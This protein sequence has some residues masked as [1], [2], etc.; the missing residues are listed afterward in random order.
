[1]DYNQKAIL[2]DAQL[3]A[4]RVQE[5]SKMWDIIRATSHLYLRDPYPVLQKEQGEEQWNPSIPRDG[6]IQSPQ[7]CLING[8]AVMAA[9]EVHNWYE[10]LERELISRH[11]SIDVKNVSREA[12]DL[13]Y[14]ITNGITHY[15][16]TF[17]DQL[18][19]K[20]RSTFPA[21]YDTSFYPRNLGKVKE[22]TKE[23]T[24]E[25]KKNQEQ[26]LQKQT[27]LPEDI[28]L[29]EQEILK[30]GANPKNRPPVNDALPYAET[31]EEIFPLWL[32][33]VALLPEFYRVQALKGK[34]DQISE[35]DLKRNIQT[36]VLQIQKMLQNA[37]HNE[38]VEDYPVPTGRQPLPRAE[39]LETKKEA[40]LP[41]IKEEQKTFPEKQSL[42]KIQPL[43]K[44]EDVFSS[45][46]FEKP[47]TE[48]RKEDVLSSPIFEEKEKLVKEDPF[49]SSIF[50]EKR[51]PS[52]KKEKILSPETEN[53]E[54][55]Q[56]WP[57]ILVD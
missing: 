4:N 31:L 15:G 47:T 50:E 7:D 19:E 44:E 29:I 13:Y 35:Q 9:T 10:F 23:L 2:V 8:Y 25:L 48:L 27:E 55:I 16:I 14:D 32:R 42:S 37:K 17:L 36:R 41:K 49:P 40:E 54:K 18:K 34:D 6:N 46:I 26:L 56:T 53:L 3:K 52:V 30:I 1:M 5:A 43:T 51:T 11:F 38:I 12:V 22:L 39:E 24:E 33:I 57:D 28:T 20:V 21:E 45:S